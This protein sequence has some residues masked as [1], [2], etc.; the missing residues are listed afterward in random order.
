M[1]G[2]VTQKSTLPI[3]CLLGKNMLNL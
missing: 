2:S 3:Y 1:S